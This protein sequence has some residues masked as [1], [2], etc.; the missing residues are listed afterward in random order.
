MK[1]AVNENIFMKCSCFCR[2]HKSNEARHL[3][4]SPNINNAFMYRLDKSFTL[5]IKTAFFKYF[6]FFS[7]C[8]ILRL[9]ILRPELL[10]WPKTLNTYTQLQWYQKNVKSRY[11]RGVFFS[12][13]QK[14]LNFRIPVG[15]ILPHKRFIVSLKSNNTAS[16]DILPRWRRT[17]TVVRSVSGYFYF[18]YFF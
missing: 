15:I 4:F 10:M 6:Y 2:N 16:A 8:N 17:P 14:R 18:I 7:W 1:C 5:R 11:S 12:K 3:K 13:A 9:L